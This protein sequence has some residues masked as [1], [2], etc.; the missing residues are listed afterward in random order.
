MRGYRD[1]LRGLS[2]GSPRWLISL[3]SWGIPVV[4]SGVPLYPFF[5]M[6]RISLAVLLLMVVVSGVFA[7]DYTV[8]IQVINGGSTAIKSVSLTKTST[9]ANNLATIAS[10]DTSGTVMQP[11]DVHTWSGSLP[12][13]YQPVG[14]HAWTTNYGGAGASTEMHS[15]Q[16]PLAI[17]ANGT[18]TLYLNGAAPPPPTNRC[19]FT[20]RNN[21]GLVRDYQLI[22]LATGLPLYGA[23]SGSFSGAT[24]ARAQPAQV[25]TLTVSSTNSC[26]DYGVE[27]MIGA[28]PS[29]GQLNGQTVWAL[30]PGEGTTDEGQMPGYTYSVTS[31]SSGWPSTNSPPIVTIPG[32][33]GGIL[34]SNSAY[35]NLPISF[36]SNGVPTDVNGSLQV[37]MSAIYQAVRESGATAHRDAENIRDVTSGGLSNV[38]NELAGINHSI[39]NSAGSGTNAYSGST[40]NL[41]RIADKYKDFTAAQAAAEEAMSGP[42][43][44]VRG[45]AGTLNGGA[46]AASGW[47]QVGEGFSYQV[48]MNVRPGERPLPTFNINPLGTL[49]AGGGSTISF[50]SIAQVARQIFNWLLVAFYARLIVDKLVETW[51]SFSHMSGL[52]IQNLEVNIAGCGGN[53]IGMLLFPLIMIAVLALWAF[54]L[55]ASLTLLFNG[56]DVSGFFSQLTTNPLTGAIP[57]GVWLVAQFFPLGTFFGLSLAYLAYHLS[58]WVVEMIGAAAAKFLLGG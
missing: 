1:V 10:W 9:G 58:Q 2:A 7:V 37:G 8:S 57:Q 6:K 12:D 17:S 27:S 45:L 52:N 5:F 11:G 3:G 21:S 49:S 39:T 36:T 34:Y 24:F 28:Y 18:Y 25:V 40:N 14:A 55:G 41:G 32:P 54:T 29:A 22:S 33:G 4:S 46:S 15:P 20:I 50:S 35:T 30:I 23:R 26:S 43:G 42:A 31:S 56:F 38:V 47:D 19:V 13:S 44:T 53:E 48:R 51:R 16:G